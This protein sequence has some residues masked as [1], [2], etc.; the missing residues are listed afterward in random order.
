MFPVPCG[1]SLSSARTV[2]ENTMLSAA[3]T[4]V[5]TSQMDHCLHQY[6]DREATGKRLGKVLTSATVCAWYRRALGGTVVVVVV[7]L[8]GAILL[9]DVDVPAAARTPAAGCTGDTSTVCSVGTTGAVGQH[10]QLPDLD[11]GDAHGQSNLGL[12]HRTGI[13]EPHEWHSPSRTRCSSPVAPA[14]HR[15]GGR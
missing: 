12:M 9:R 2:L 6:L 3:V 5:H 11:R 7:F 10:P 13:G 14:R 1:P 4:G 15:P 8:G